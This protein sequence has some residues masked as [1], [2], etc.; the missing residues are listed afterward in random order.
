M[1]AK[2]NIMRIRKRTLW[3]I[4]ILLF[5]AL[6]CGCASKKTVEE[7]PFFEKWKVMAEEARAHSPS[8]KVR[9]IE[10][11]QEKK[12][13]VQEEEKEVVPEKPLP[14]QKISLSMHDMPVP[15][16]LRAL[17]K[18]AG[19]N[20]MINA[21]VKGKININVEAAPWDQVFLGVLRTKGLTYSWEG[22][23]IRIVSV[24]DM[25]HD[26]K[27]ESIQEKRKAQEMELRRVEPLLT[28]I[29]YIDYAEANKI[30]ENLKEFLTKDKEGKPRGSI[31]V[32]EHTNALVI[33]AIRD[34][35]I[36]MIPLI[37]K[38]DRP[39][40]QIM[41]EAN[42]IETTRETALELGVRWGGLYRTSSGNRNLWI[43]PGANT[44]GDMSN[45]LAPGIDPTTGYAADFPADFVTTGGAGFTLGILTEKIGRSLLS[46]EL[47]ALQ[48]EGKLN[49]LSSPS[50][51]TLDN[52]IAFTENG[53]KV[54]Y[55]STDKDGNREVKFEEA[56]LRLEI[57][58]HVIDGK[59]LRMDITVKK[60]EV[61]TSRT[62]DGNPFIIKKQTE[63]SLI[64]EDDETIVI[65]GLTR[66]RKLGSEDGIPGLKDIPLLGYLFKGINKEN[67]MEDVLI[68]I[69]PHIL[70]KKEPDKNT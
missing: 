33:Q 25:E 2:E 16:L 23:I 70:K 24:E 65:S 3:L 43:T 44:G 15:V 29:V 4:F 47:S 31:M 62:V 61:D 35:I 32:D 19:Q 7:D 17:A 68:F 8:E 38:L 63:T 12:G 10:L 28:K 11:P 5:M 42:I 14:T 58:P 18:I 53:E 6:A 13:A 34:D 56:V 37:Q 26:L 30:K 64:V 55:V 40:P 36:R 1:L 48:G 69:T 49:I 51:T 50:L 59:H 67:L 57:K 66:Q 54:P 22:D 60:D 41:I 45:P 46:Y 52:Q 9:S 27:M 21:D 20:I 39:T